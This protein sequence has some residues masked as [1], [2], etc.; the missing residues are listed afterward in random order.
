MTL[1]RDLR[2]FARSDGVKV[3]TRTRPWA[4]DPERPNSGIQAMTTTDPVWSEEDW[5]LVVGAPPRIVAA[6]PKGTPER[7]KGVVLAHELGH[8]EEH[9]EIYSTPMP[10]SDWNNR[11]PPPGP[12]LALIEGQTWVRAWKLM[13]QLG[14]T[15]TEGDR[16]VAELAL[17]TYIRFA[18]GPMADRFVQ[19]F[20]WK[21][22][23]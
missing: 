19:T 9:R 21:E 10:V 8:A 18:P 16:E 12:R 23:V 3:R 6:F 11:I 14:H 1:Y 5:R 17:R 4:W 13:R 20:V 2:A 15:P 7:V 22:D